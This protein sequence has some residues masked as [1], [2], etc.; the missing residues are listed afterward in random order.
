MN[1][2]PNTKLVICQ[3][4]PLDPSYEHTIHFGYAREYYHM[5]DQYDYF[6]SKRKYVFEPTTYQRV[7]SNKIRI[8]MIADNLYN[9]NYMMFQNTN[10][11]TE[12]KHYT[13]DKWFYAFITK[14]EYINNAVTEITY[15]LDVMQ[16]WMFDYVI[17]WSFVER[18][19]SYSDNIGDNLVPE[20]LVP[21]SY[22]TESETIWP[23]V[24]P[25]ATLPGYHPHCMIL[26][27]EMPTQGGDS[28]RSVKN[29]GGIPCNCLCQVF[30]M[31][32]QRTEFETQLNA[33]QGQENKIIGLYTVPPIFESIPLGDNGDSL[34]KTDY[35][36]Y[37]SDNIYGGTFDGYI[38]RN[39]KMYTYPF[40]KL[41]LENSFGQEKE[42]KFELFSY[43]SDGSITFDVNAAVLPK[44]GMIIYP[45][46]YANN[47]ANIEDALSI[48]EYPQGAFIGDSFMMWMNQGFI[49]D[50]ASIST[51]GLNLAMFS[52]SGSDY[53][54][55]HIGGRTLV[56]A[57]GNTIAHG[58]QAHLAPDQVYGNFEARATY[59]SH[60][61]GY[62]F[63]LKTERPVYSQA[64]MIDDFFTRFGYAQNQIMQVETYAR[65]H[66]TYTKTLDCT[67]VGSIPADDMQKIRSVFNN[68]ITWWI[69]PEEIGDYTLDNS[70]K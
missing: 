61:A 39:N 19:H 36:N 43:N 56:T 14:V 35:V 32:T 40:N 47:Q 22:V 66:W 48:G 12:S 37:E 11:R 53:V 55:E 6:Y 69:N 8:Q 10:F 51:A 2:S 18:Q 34:I 49:Q 30:D 70:P 1:I 27:T 3:D 67:I 65:K 44:P 4:V 33:Y 28:M 64:K 54:A 60:P 7:N 45:R 17:S 20:T 46:R 59:Y 62:S 41:K 16:T 50:L 24:V 68:G 15:E 29:V 38:P 58:L 5:A 21:S 52:G 25:N 26:A 9:C 63:K 42:Y 23:I 57:V 13:G 31:V